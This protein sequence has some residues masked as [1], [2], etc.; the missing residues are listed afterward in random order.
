MRCYDVITVWTALWILFF[1]VPPALLTAQAL[2]GG[3]APSKAVGNPPPE[4]PALADLI[5]LEAALPGRLATLQQKIGDLVIP[6]D[7]EK[8]LA[9]IDVSL[10]A[11]TN[12]FER[13]RSATGSDYYRFIALKTTLRRELQSLAKS[14]TTLMKMLRQLDDW[15]TTWEAE[16]QQWGTWQLSGH[17]DALLDNV[18]QTFTRAHDTIDAALNLVRQQ[19]KPLLAGQEQ[20]RNLQVRLDVLMAQVE[21]MIAAVGDDALHHVTP[22][23]IS[24]RYM[25]QFDSRLWYDTR[26]G[27]AEIA[28]P[29]SQFIARQGW[30]MF[31][32]A[33]LS[34]VVILVVVR[35][36]AVLGQSADWQF[37]ATRPI[38]AGCFVG[39]MT[40]YVFYEWS[41]ITVTIAYTVLVGGAFVRLLGGLLEASWKK[42]LVATMVILLITTRLS[43][44]LNLPQPLLRLYVLLAALVGLLCFLR[45]AAQSA[46]NGDMW[47]YPLTLRLAACLFGVIL[48]AELAGQ[49]ELAEYLLV[50]SIRSLL[51][52]L[53]FS[54]LRYLLHKGLAAAMQRAPSNSLALLRSNTEIVVRRMTL[55]ADTLIGVVVVAGLLASWGVYDNPMAA[56]SGLLVIGVDVGG[57]RVNVGHIVSAIVV[58]FSAFLVSGILQRLLVP[59]V[60][61][62]RQVETGVQIA[63]AR[64][65][66]YA[67]VFI[68][69]VLALTTLGFELTHLTILLS[70]MGVGIGFGLQ[71]MVNNFLCG[72]ILLF[73]RPIRVGDTIELGDQLARIHKI[74]LRATTVQ[75]LEQA[76]VILPNSD[77]INHQVINW[78]LTNRHAR[79]TI[80]VGVAYGSD[81][82]LVM[83]TLAACSAES[84]IVM[85]APKPLVLFRQFGDSTL[86]FELRVWIWNVDN[87]MQAVSELHQ[88]IDRRFREVGIEIAFPQRD[89]HIR[90][91]DTSDTAGLPLL[92]Q[93][94]S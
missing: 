19:I 72:L 27:L 39:G 51:I 60:L 35:Y 1:S 5:P 20:I 88:E 82:P 57:K 61:A 52:I 10:Q 73:E 62:R 37:V 33:L 48:L 9:S 31:F 40:T 46:R 7:I 85:D 67:L 80:P 12:Q 42:Q 55:L 66:H 26:N 56:L 29:D 89:L 41:F 59:G 44:A 43:E 15:R 30:I 54:L 71:A 83:Q 28:W 36:R 58:L 77:L 25:M 50:S 93:P 92:Q 91:V 69:F 76:D 17:H 49:A 64:L 90:S 84:T 53:A 70:A 78:T 4:H 16:K 74:G 22:P 24:T 47:L 14:S 45:W 68:G 3:T 79:I 6:R 2:P 18:E 94:G 32:Q 65:L 34:L 75:T 11:Y 13:L 81:V 87:R 63:I 86:D 8:R 21:G 38:A 23:I